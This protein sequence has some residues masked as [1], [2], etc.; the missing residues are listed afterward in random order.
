MFNVTKLNDRKHE[1]S[2]DDIVRGK[3][4]HFHH[5]RLLRYTS[6]RS[7]CNRRVYVRRV[8]ASAQQ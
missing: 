6:D 5:V 4:W 7:N 8:L 2:F 1:K 3:S